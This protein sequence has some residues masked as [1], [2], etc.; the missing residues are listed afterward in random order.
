[1]Y[2]YQGH[3]CL[4]INQEE[5]AVD[6]IPNQAQFELW[7]GT[8]LQFSLADDSPYLQDA[9]VSLSLV[10][11]NAIQAL[12]KDY[13]EKNKATN[14]LSFP[15]DFPEE[16]NLPLLGD[17]IICPRI[18]EEEAS[19]QNKSLESHW[20]HLCIH[21]CLHLLGFD[22][23]EDSEAEIMESLETKIMLDLSY[24]APYSST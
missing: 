21:G 15:T 18:L 11:P 9:E 24:L 13:R 8:A 19:A 12:N 5:Q 4:D 6:F 17:I 16:L 10:E 2:S 22:H 14:V 7:I 20:A 1:M 3:L 23:I